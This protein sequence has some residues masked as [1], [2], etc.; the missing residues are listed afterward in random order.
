MYCKILGLLFVF[1]TEQI[2]RMTARLSFALGLQSL[3][4][5]SLVLLSEAKELSTSSECSRMLHRVR[6]DNLKV[7]GLLPSCF[8]EKKRQKLGG[9][10][11]NE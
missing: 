8:S 11:G 5:L 4:T 6:Q 3:V 10:K 2:D 9:V 7:L 1:L